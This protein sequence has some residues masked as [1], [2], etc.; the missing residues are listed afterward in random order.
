MCLFNYGYKNMSDNNKKF[1]WVI[2]SFLI[3]Y[4]VL[5]LASLPFYFYYCSPSWG[6]YLISI[7]L[8]YATGLSITGG[9]HRLY[10]HRSFRTNKVVEFIV[11]FFASMAGQGSALRWSFDHRLH[12]AHVDTEDD[13][14]SIK[15]GFWYAHF[16]WMLYEQK[17]IDQKIVPDLFQN[18]YVLFQHRYYPI[19]MFGINLLTFLAIGYFLNDFWGAFFLAWWTRFFLL[20]HFTWFINSLAHT[21]GDKPFC[22]EQSAVN[23]YILAFLTFGEG[24]HNYH[25]TFAN[26]Y[27][28]GI[29]WF[30]F[31][32]TKWV[33]WTLAYFGLAHQL[34]TVDAYTIQKRMI[35]EKKMLLLQQVRQLWYV[36]KEEIEAKI[37]EMSDRIETNIQIFNQLKSQ[38]LKMQSHQPICKELLSEI[39]LEISAVKQRIR[40]D[41]RNWKALCSSLTRL[42]PLEI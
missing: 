9:Y 23:N 12:H 1:N 11:L 29:R 40:E 28:N 37:H 5:L 8:L 17:P 26:D 35:R 14:Y 4:Q 27:R 36:K 41:W 19:L 22:Q 38:Y 34:R 20:H 13:P 31:D 42:K 32:P 24:Y 6:M 30:H 39:N 15:K 16:F 33:I 3:A 7:V 18:K 25:H 10:S 2:G 21:W